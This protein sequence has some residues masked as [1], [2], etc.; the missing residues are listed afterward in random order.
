MKKCKKKGLKSLSHPSSLP[1]LPHHISSKFKKQ[2]Q[3]NL[4]YD[5]MQKTQENNVNIS[6][7]TTVSISLSEGTFLLTASK[8]VCS[9]NQENM[10][11]CNI[12]EERSQ[13]SRKNWRIWDTWYQFLFPCILLY[14]GSNTNICIS[15]KTLHSIVLYCST[16]G[17]P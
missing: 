3:P 7:T 14:M 12:T 11:G 17:L 6:T 13:I 10:I 5:M 8:S 1:T 15:N 4:S 2:D 9:Q 16:T